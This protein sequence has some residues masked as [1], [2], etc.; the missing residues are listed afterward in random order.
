MVGNLLVEGGARRAAEAGFLRYS[1][2]RACGLRWR[3]LLE[4][5]SAD[6]SI[7]VFR[8][9]RGSALVLQSWRCFRIYLV[10]LAERSTE[11]PER[12]SP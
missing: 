5:D 4:R 9:K 10:V 2:K 12:I 6:A 1:Y 8:I 3:V 7:Y 11:A